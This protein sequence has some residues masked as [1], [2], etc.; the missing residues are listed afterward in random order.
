MRLLE[1]VNALTFGMQL[2]PSKLSYTNSL[3]QIKTT[4]SIKSNQVYLWTNTSSTTHTYALTAFCRTDGGLPGCLASGRARDAGEDETC[5]AAS[6]AA[7]VTGIE[8]NKN[9]TKMKW[10]PA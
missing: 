2:R 9:K 7:V 4:A 6:T 1:Q 3:T 8:A 10:L 5:E